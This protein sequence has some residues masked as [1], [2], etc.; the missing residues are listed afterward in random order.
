MTE[1]KRL[2]TVTADDWNR[3]YREADVPWDSGLPSA[4]LRRFIES[5][6]PSRGA[7]LEIGCGTGTN[8]VYLAQQG[9][10]VTAIDVS[11]LAIEQAEAKARTAQ[12]SVRFIC[13]DIATLE[14]DGAFEFL[15]DRGCYHCV[16]RAGLLPQYLRAVARFMQAG[17]QWLVLCGNADDT[18]PGGPPKL[19]AAQVVADFEPLCRIERIA[20][21]RFEDAGGVPGPL[22][23][24]C[25]LSRRA[26]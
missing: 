20:A 23:W 24:S 1:P 9:F 7:A 18:A 2:P 25:L 3:R 6:T 15:F 17:S 10:D 8:A 14:L 26:D 11:P 13:G 4:E 21:F 12:V 5:E 19:T 22:G 16:R